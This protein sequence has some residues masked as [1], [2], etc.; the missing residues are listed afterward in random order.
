MLVHD[1]FGKGFIKTMKVSFI[2]LKHLDKKVTFGSFVCLLYCIGHE[3]WPTENDASITVYS[4]N[5]NKVSLS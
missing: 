3:N 5:V 1:A 2:V 4:F